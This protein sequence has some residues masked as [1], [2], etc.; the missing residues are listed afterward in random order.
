MLQSYVDTHVRTRRGKN[1]A[2][3]KQTLN[4]IGAYVSFQEMTLSWFSPLP[5]E[6]NGQASL[7]LNSGKQLH[8]CQDQGQWQPWPL[9]EHCTGPGKDEAPCTGNRVE[10]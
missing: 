6:C 7:A 5:K 4:F 10:L 3:P 1:G 2:W 8:V 9:T